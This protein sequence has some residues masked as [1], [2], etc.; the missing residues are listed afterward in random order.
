MNH[1]END[2]FRQ[3]VVVFLSFFFEGENLFRRHVT[4]LSEKDIMLTNGLCK[5]F[6]GMILTKSQTK[7]NNHS[8][9]ICFFITS[10]NACTTAEAL[11]EYMIPHGIS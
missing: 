4:R 1:I 6:V 9:D 5:L 10:T 7:Y 3:K 11:L 2:N 8:A